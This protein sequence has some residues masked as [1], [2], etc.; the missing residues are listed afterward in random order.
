MTR[1]KDNVHGGA[2]WETGLSIGE[3]AALME[4]SER[5]LRHWDSVGLVSPER[6]WSG[7]RRY[8]QGDIARLERV[9]I[10]RELGLKTRRIRELLDSPTPLAL[11]ELQGQRSQIKEKIHRLEAALGTLDR[12]IAIAEGREEPGEPMTTTGETDRSQLKEAQERW[13]TSQQWMEYA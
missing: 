3:T 5:M 7:Y 11:E 13:G 12:L 4:V 1:D 9:L 8:A 10:Y 6:N 2:A